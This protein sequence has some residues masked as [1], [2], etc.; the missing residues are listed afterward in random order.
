M[1]LVCWKLMDKL[2]YHWDPLMSDKW[3]QILALQSSDYRW[4]TQITAVEFM[5]QQDLN[6][7][8]SDVCIYQEASKSN[9][10][11]YCPPLG[12]TE[13]LSREWENGF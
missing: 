7:P 3:N 2:T 5:R 4:S 11:K 10:I 8:F 1:R 12:S 9:A 6:L 13:P